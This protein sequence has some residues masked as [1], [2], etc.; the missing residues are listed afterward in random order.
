MPS[1]LS[2][3]T[4]ATGLGCGRDR[5]QNDRLSPGPSPTSAAAAVAGNCRFLA[6]FRSIF[7]G[8]V[9]RRPA[10]ISDDPGIKEFRRR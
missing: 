4:P 2:L 8:F 9:R 10:T 1:S 6:G 7:A 3:A 5:C